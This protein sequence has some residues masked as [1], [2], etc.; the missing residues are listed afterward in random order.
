MR[1]GAAK[2]KFSIATR[3]NTPFTCYGVLA[4]G[5]GIP[6]L[7]A[8]DG[9]VQDRPI[10]DTYCSYPG[11]SSYFVEQTEAT[12]T[13]DLA[14]PRG[15]E[16]RRIQ[17]V[18]LPLESGQACPTDKTVAE[19]LVDARKRSASGYARGYFGLYEVG[20]TTATILGPVTL[21]IIE[22]E[23]DANDLHNLMTCDGTTEY[24]DFEISPTSVT[25]HSG[26]KYRF[27]ASGSLMPSSGY[28]F[29]TLATASGV[30]TSSSP[31]NGDYTAPSSA[32][33]PFTVTAKDSFAN[34]RKAVVTVVNLPAVPAYWFRGDIYWLKGDAYSLIGSDGWQSYGSLSQNLTPGTPGITFYQASGPYG[35]PALTFSGSAAFSNTVIQGAFTQVT[36]FVVA[37]ATGTGGLFCAADAVC[38]AT[39]GSLSI[40]RSGG[41]IYAEARNAS[42]DTT[43]TA[44]DPGTAFLAILH[45][46]PAVALELT[47][48][49][50]G[51]SDQTVTATSPIAGTFTPTILDLGRAGPAFN[52]QIAEFILYDGS[53]TLANKNAVI[54]YLKDKY[55]LE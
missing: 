47:I 39:P 24:S 38:N 20:K 28:S 43:A 49:A 29:P 27:T 8:R 34:S 37:K 25:L 5:P 53:L 51:I 22:S 50:P 10:A 9:L 54:K 16:E 32:G 42:T 7:D 30:I 12:V 46:N 4:N 55:D 26:G 23:Y 33:G 41:G 14:I 35:H 36:A 48:V 21:P 3:A 17:V 40:V 6:S 2:M 19:F 45:W 31:T 13:M 15:Y 52:G 44:T 1:G 11:A 18:G